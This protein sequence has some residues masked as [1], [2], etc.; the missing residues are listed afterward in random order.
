VTVIY[1]RGER[2]TQAQIAA[3]FEEWKRRQDADP[4]GTM[5]IDDVLAMSPE[6]YGKVAARTFAL[7]AVDLAYA[8]IEAPTEVPA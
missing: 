1:S 2:V 8:M 3:I 7:I 6:E 4:D 5:P